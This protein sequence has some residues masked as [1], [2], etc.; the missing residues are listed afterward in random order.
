MTVPLIGSCV[1]KYVI[2]NNLSKLFINKKITVHLDAYSDK[3]HLESLFSLCII[4]LSDF[5]NIL[6]VFRG[7]SLIQC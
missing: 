2:T 5:L 3:S 1:L 6:I 7:E 4:S